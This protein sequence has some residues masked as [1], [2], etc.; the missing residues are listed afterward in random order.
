MSPTT[1]GITTAIIVIVVLMISTILAQFQGGMIVNGFLWFGTYLAI[2]SIYKKK[3]SNE[4]DKMKL[5]K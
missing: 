1:K 3:E 2:R 5:E 4:T